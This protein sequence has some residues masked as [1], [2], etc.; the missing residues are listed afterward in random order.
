LFLDATK[1]GEDAAMEAA[2]EAGAQDFVLDGEEYVVSTT[3]NDIHA[4]KDALAAKG[5]AISSSE[6][7]MVPKN[8]VK[9]EGADAQKLFKLIDTLEELDDV[10]KVF[11]N[12]DI[13]AVD[14]AEAEA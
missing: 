8:T 10:S 13:D 6:I 1:H 12:L 14:L 5:F 3:P 4:V 11:T 2:L 9:V 7:A